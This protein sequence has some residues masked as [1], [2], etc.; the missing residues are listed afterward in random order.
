MIFKGIY[1]MFFFN[2]K[3]GINKTMCKRN[4]LIQSSLSNVVIALLLIFI[5][6]IVYQIRFL[7]K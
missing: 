5:K 1:G 3:A 4:T 6:R 2:V 7:L